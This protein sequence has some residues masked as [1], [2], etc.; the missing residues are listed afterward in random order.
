[1][2]VL[3][4]GVIHHVIHP[5]FCR[6]VAHVMAHVVVWQA[7]H[8]KSSTNSM[9]RLTSI[10]AGAVCSEPRSE[11]G[12][13]QVTKGPL[14]AFPCDLG[15]AQARAS[16]ERRYTSAALLHTRQLDPALK[17]HK[18]VSATRQDGDFVSCLP[19]VHSIK[20]TP[21]RVRL[22]TCEKHYE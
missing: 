15:P 16:T 10:P 4:T 13:D 2:L 19:A 14:A 11:A 18:P 9:L 21:W 3:L 8:T 20:C 17:K 22:E 12:V 7:S 5:G 6:L 1:M